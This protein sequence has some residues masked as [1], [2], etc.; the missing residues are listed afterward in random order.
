M[1]PYFAPPSRLVFFGLEL[2][3]FG[4]LLSTSVLVTY[5]A[6]IHRGRA[7]GLAEPKVLSRFAQGLLLSG[8]L[9]A[10]LAGVVSDHGFGAF[11]R[12]ALLF[13][14]TGSFSSAAGLA[15]AG[16]VGVV[17]LR[18]LRLPVR[19]FADVVAWSFPFGLLVSR[20][21]CALTHDHPG[22][23]SSSWLAVSFPEGPRFDCGLLE[24]MASPFLVGLVLVLGRARRPPGFLAGLTGIAY[25]L[26][27]F[28]LDFLRAEDLPRSDPRYVGLTLAQWVC[29]PVLI[30]CIALLAGR[31]KRASA[32]EM[33]SPSDSDTPTKSMEPPG[34]HPGE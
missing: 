16:V 1:I 13:S 12:P 21:G 26:V 23:L 18:V 27:R 14:S 20:A 31:N 7:V 28:P 9:G 8:V 15:L 22:R 5:A 19:G 24:W 34:A 30:G 3:V 32:P 29:L 11:V 10:H 6:L 25:V 2:P 17:S 33:P 4:L